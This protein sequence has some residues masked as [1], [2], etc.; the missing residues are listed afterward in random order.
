MLNCLKLTHFLKY[1]I[2]F[3]VNAVCEWLVLYHHILDWSIVQKMQAKKD[4][5]FLYKTWHLNNQQP[6]LTSIK[7]ILATFS[8]NKLNPVRNITASD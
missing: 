2:I 5:R 1:A 8:S 6:K 4:D 3:K 7:C